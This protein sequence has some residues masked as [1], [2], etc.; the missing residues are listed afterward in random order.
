M[1]EDK[2]RVM[3]IVAHP[4]DAEFGSAGTVARWVAEGREVTY[5]ICTNGDKG[6]SDPEMTPERLARIREQEQREAARVLGVKEVVFLGYPDGGLEDTPQFRGEVV[7][8]IR[9][10]RPDIVLTSDPYRRYMQH[11]DHRIA[12]TVALDAVYPYA[13]DRLFYPEHLAQGLRPHKVK[14]VYIWGSDN[15]NAF[16]DITATFEQKLAALSCHKSQIRSW[17]WEQL[18]ERMR[19]MAASYGQRQGMELAE[20][21]YRFE[22]PW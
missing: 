9:R 16:I 13:R 19:R 4:D 6:S 5:L 15:P 22:F 12:G 18:K 20:A 17:P 21:F 1:A 14:E 8:E 10:Y 2:I 7:R 11:R 3:A